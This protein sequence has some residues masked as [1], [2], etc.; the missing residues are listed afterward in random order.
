MRKWAG[1]AA[2]VVLVA[3]SLLSAIDLASAQDS[4]PL[5]EFE[6]V[7]EQSSVRFLG[8]GITEW[9]YISR[10]LQASFTVIA[11]SVGGFFA[12]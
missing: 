6:S 10:I 7:G 2:A 9:T 5:E 11:I 3:F 8:L 1:M 4:S 12:W